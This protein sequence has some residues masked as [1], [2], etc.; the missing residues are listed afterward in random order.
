MAL[1]TK[2]ARGLYRVERA[3]RVFEV[4][5]INIASDGDIPPAWMLYEVI[6]ENQ[7]RAFWNDFCTKASAI[8]AVH[9]AV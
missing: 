5:N 4:E 1:S 3:G 6:G 9:A 8:A 7:T 2:I